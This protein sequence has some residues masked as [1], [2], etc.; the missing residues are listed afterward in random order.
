M[1]R[2][3]QRIRAFVQ[4][5]ERAHYVRKTWPTNARDEGNVQPHGSQSGENALNLLSVAQLIE[6]SLE[7]NAA[8]AGEGGVALAVD[9]D[10]DR[11]TPDQLRR[12]VRWLGRQPIPVI[13]LDR[14]G[15]KRDGV[16]P[17]AEELD[18]RVDDPSTL[19]RVHQKIHANPQASAVLV[20][21]L[22]AQ[23]TLEVTG[24]L[25]LES[26][27]YATL[28]AGSEFRTWL[29]TSGRRYTARPESEQEPLLVRRSGSSLHLTL[30]STHNRNALSRAMRDALSAAFKLVLMD[31][32]IH[33]VLVDAE[34]PCFSAG[35]DLS[36][37]GSMQD[38]AMAHAIRMQRMPAQYLAACADRCEF[39]VHGAAI[40]AGIELS[41]FAGRLVATSD[42]LFRLPEVGMGLIPGAGGCVSVPRRI[43][44]QKTALMAILGEDVDA[45]TALAWGLIDAIVD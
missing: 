21:V 22:R 40:G 2:S 19:E 42:T 43:G 37:F 10:T 25:A 7:P 12:L 38:Q 13:G 8:D 33:A 30:A 31:E 5:C 17:L 39:R 24:A 6:L 27:G 29:T 14:P 3:P 11:A 9:L 32:D 26:L 44:R 34:G 36:E 18:V 1:A 4:A 23:A 35:G 28:Q 41:A 15:K 45:P 20:Q 16:S